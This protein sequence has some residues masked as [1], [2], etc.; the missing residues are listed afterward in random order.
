MP[1]LSPQREVFCNCIVA[2]MTQAAAARKAGYTQKNA[3]V[4]GSQLAAKSAIKQRISEIR[5]EAES[6][7]KLTD[8]NA[9][10]RFFE[11][12]RE[13]S[14]ANLSSRVMVVDE[15]GKALGV[16]QLFSPAGKA[17]S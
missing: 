12:V 13:R 3:H 4:V 5:L 9:A 17:V 6:P 1:K 11:K 14:E 2:G 10:R 7:I 16:V 15:S 8:T